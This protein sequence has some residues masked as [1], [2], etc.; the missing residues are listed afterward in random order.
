MFARAVPRFESINKFLRQPFDDLISFLS[1]ETKHRQTNRHV[2]ADETAAFDEADFQSIFS[3]SES[4]S[5]SRRP[6]ADNKHIVF[7]A[8][9]NG[10]FRFFDGSDLGHK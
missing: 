9:A 3:R 4:G 10:A 8:N 2:A 6:A 5:Q 7:S 1:E